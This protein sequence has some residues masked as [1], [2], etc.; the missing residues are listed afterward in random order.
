MQLLATWL[1]SGGLVMDLLLFGLAPL[2]AVSRR[3]HKWTRLE[4][5][6]G[7]GGCPPLVREVNSRTSPHLRPSL[8]LGSRRIVQFLD[9]SSGL[10]HLILASRNFFRQFCLCLALTLGVGVLTT[11]VYRSRVAGIVT[12]GIQGRSLLVS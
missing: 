10:L 4:G 11:G 12:V 5:F 3:V 6:S 2:V 8:W 1:E 9:S 7:K